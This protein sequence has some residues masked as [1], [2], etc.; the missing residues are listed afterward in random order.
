[1]QHREWAPYH[2]G[3]C[4]CRFDDEEFEREI[5]ELRTAG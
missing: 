4:E 1:M 3:E 5:L 2:G